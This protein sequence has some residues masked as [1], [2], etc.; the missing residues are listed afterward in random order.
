MNAPLLMT[1]KMIS[2]QNINDFF[3]YIFSNGSHPHQGV[4]SLATHN[5]NLELKESF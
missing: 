1:T 3:I 4:A 2:S 5:V